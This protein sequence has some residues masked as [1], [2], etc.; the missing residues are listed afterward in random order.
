MLATTGQ[1]VPNAKKF[2][3]R[4]GCAWSGYPHTFAFDTLRIL[5]QHQGHLDPPGPV[6]VALKAD[7]EI[8]K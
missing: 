8:E 3:L 1:P 5:Q 7:P 2:C 4:G 6:F